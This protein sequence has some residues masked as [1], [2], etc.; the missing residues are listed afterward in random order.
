MFSKYLSR[1]GLFSEL[2]V[3]S[4]KSFGINT[5]LTYITKAVD[6]DCGV[7]A[8]RR[9]NIDRSTIEVQ[10]LKLF[11]ILTSLNVMKLKSL[12]SP[13]LAA[14]PFKTK[15]PLSFYSYDR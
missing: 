15:R 9:R 7:A 1:S 8:P 2:I 11:P 3:P 5:I 4:Q 14:D 10:K 13:T 12:P 6:E